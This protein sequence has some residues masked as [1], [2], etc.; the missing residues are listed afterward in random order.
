V[1]V[2]Q[3]VQDR[4]VRRVIPWQIRHRILASGGL[5]EIRALDAEA[6]REGHLPDGERLQVESIWV[7]ECY[8]PSCLDGLIAGLESL[9][10]G[11]RYAS[12]ESAAD[13]V[14]RYRSGAYLGGTYNLGFFSRPGPAFIG[15]ESARTDLPATVELARGWLEDLTPSL[16]AIAVQFV[17]TEEAGSALQK[18]LNADYRTTAHATRWGVSYQDPRNQRREAVQET[19]RRLTKDCS[20]WINRHMPGAFG[21]NLVHGA[22]PSCVFVTTV[23]ETPYPKRSE[24]PIWRSWMAAAELDRDHEAWESIDWPGLWLRVPDTDEECGRWWFAGRRGDF[25]NDEHQAAYGGATPRGWV[26]RLDSEMS[27]TL[28]LHATSSLL[29]AMHELVSVSR[30]SMGTKSARKWNL[31]RLESLRTDLTSFVR[32][33][34]PVASELKNA[35]GLDRHR[36]T[37][38][39]GPGNIRT[40]IRTRQPKSAIETTKDSPW[41]RVWTRPC[42]GP[43]RRSEPGAKAPEPPAALASELSELI[44]HRAQRLVE[45]ERLHRDALATI[46]TLVAAGESIHLDRR[47]FW[48]TMVLGFVG[49]VAALPALVQVAQVVLRQVGIDVGR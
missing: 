20:G 10:V 31:R 26:N 24:R 44:R 37:F 7:M 39:P 28:M 6:N 30:D 18:A 25:L 48:L 21:T 33:V 45:A 32:D 41:W 5:A 2:D 22:A 23:M 34:E 4:R 14:R 43:Y 49:L 29:L 46:S 3:L 12:R 15:A 36:A 40:L 27:L 17:L 38:V 16:T 42:G 13:V 47:L 8:P 1:R 11:D 9:H 35:V 19:L